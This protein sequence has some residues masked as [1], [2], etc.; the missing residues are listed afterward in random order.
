MK[1][2][3]PSQFKI[4][5]NFPGVIAAIALGILAFRYIAPFGREVTYTFV[6]KLPGA[7]DFINVYAAS[8]D[9][10]RLAAQVI[11]NK[12][13]RFTLKADAKNLDMITAR[14][15]FKTGQREIRLGVRGNESQSFLYRPLYFSLLENLDWKN[16]SGDGLTLWQKNPNFKTV[17]EFIKSPPKDKKI[18]TYQID[19][20]SLINQNTLSKEKGSFTLGATQIRG[21]VSLFVLVNQ[22]SLIIKFAKQDTNM[23]DGEDKLRAVLSR[24]TSFVTEK[25]LGDD[26]ITDK[27]QLKSLPQE[28]QFKIDNL[29]PGIYQLDFIFDSKGSDSLI[30]KVDINQKKVVINKTALFIGNSATRLYTDSKKVIARTLHDASFQKIKLDAK[31]DLDI[32]KSKVDFNFNL[33]KLSKNKAKD[34]LFELMIP[35]NDLT[36][37]T[38]GYLALTRGGYFTP[39]IM[40]SSDLSDFTELAEVKKQFDYI[41]TSLPSYSKK[42]DWYEVATNFDARDITIAKD[43]LFFSLEIPEL[44]KHGGSLDIAAFDITLK[45]KSLVKP[46]PTSIVKLVKQNIITRLQKVATPTA[47]P[48]RCL[49]GTINIGVGQSYWYKDNCSICTCQAGGKIV[50]LPKFCKK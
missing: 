40:K 4:V 35:K 30:T 21:N 34:G 11:K 24:G 23:Y 43:S 25:A 1:K 37:T 45:D 2:I 44:D 36:I 29:K 26:G 17:A 9:S 18:A 8:T 14:L 19:P 20:N 15:K 27:S 47:N 38:D 50:C 42:G 49:Q 31:T 6:Q 3:S 5:I 32:N 39:Q 48:N 22:P 13:S 7:E 46:S 10:L 33:D 12:T 28:T 16:I 41:L